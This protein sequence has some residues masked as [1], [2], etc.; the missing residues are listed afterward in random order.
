MASKTD[1]SERAT[2]RSRRKIT[3]LGLLALLPVFVVGFYF[4]Q[5]WSGEARLRE[6][7]EEADRLDPNW[8]SRWPTGA[9]DRPRS[10]FY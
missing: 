8:R 5:R 4:Y 6:A 10:A 9:T 7:I 2:R 3:V 1:S